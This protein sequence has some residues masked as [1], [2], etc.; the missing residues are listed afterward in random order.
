MNNF[1]ND[2]AKI[3]TNY[4]TFSFDWNWI[5]TKTIIHKGNKDYGMLWILDEDGE[6]VKMYGYELIKD[7]KERR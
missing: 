3:E 2:R 1:D 6:A 7:E 4:V 5:K